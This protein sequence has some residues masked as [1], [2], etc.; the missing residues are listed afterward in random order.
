[1]TGLTNQ[2]LVFS[3]W[4]IQHT[5]LHIQYLPLF[6]PELRAEPS[7]VVGTLPDMQGRTQLEFPLAESFYTIV[8]SGQTRALASTMDRKMRGWSEPETSIST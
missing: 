6:P 2:R 5:R 1:M 8:G 7:C 3:D 4:K